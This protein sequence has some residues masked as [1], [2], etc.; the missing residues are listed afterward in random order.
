MYQVKCQTQVY[1]SMRRIS[2]GV[3]DENRLPVYLRFF[4]SSILLKVINRSKDFI[5]NINQISLAGTIVKQMYTNILKRIINRQTNIKMPAGFSINYTCLISPHM[6]PKNV[7]AERK[8]RKL[9]V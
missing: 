7:F 5:K 3:L 1:N 4:S 9:F 6:K 2:Y 8:R